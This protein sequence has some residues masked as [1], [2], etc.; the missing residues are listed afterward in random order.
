VHR[1]LVILEPVET[2][3]DS[4]KAL[5]TVDKGTISKS[6]GGT[7]IGGVGTS[8][9]SLPRSGLDIDGE[10]RLQL[11]R[12]LLL[13]TEWIVEAGQKHGQAVVARYKLA[14]QLRPGWEK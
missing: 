1:A 2:D 14:L 7:A 10:E 4:L 8:S 5:L 11:A 6:R 13:T 9:S 3:V 12:K